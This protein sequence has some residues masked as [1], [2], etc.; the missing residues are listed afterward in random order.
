MAEQ[1]GDGVADFSSAQQENSMHL[2]LHE[3][4]T[5]EHR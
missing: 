5:D 2:F 3:L 1:L 4:T